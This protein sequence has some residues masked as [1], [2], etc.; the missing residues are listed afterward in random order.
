MDTWEVQ[1]FEF[2]KCYNYKHT[3][4]YS[5]GWSFDLCKRYKFIWFKLVQIQESSCTTQ[6]QF[7]LS[8]VQVLN[9][10]DKN[11]AP[12]ESTSYLQAMQEL[13]KLKKWQSVLQLLYLDLD[14]CLKKTKKPK[15]WLQDILLAK[16]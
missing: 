9:L 14:F 1:E 5:D 10:A 2:V 13:S 12:K 11:I 4:M 15:R 16:M 6:Q 7:T 8:L 3:Q